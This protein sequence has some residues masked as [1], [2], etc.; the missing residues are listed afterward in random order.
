MGFAVIHVEKS[1]GNCFRTVNC[2]NR[3]WLQVVS[4]DGKVP[5]PN[6]CGYF[7]FDTTG[8]TQA[9]V[10]VTDKFPHLFIDAKLR[11]FEEKKKKD[12]RKFLTISVR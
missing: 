11:R 1:L 9:P 4:N 5:N 6:R 7:V 10:G 2:R 3:L 8:S 12:C